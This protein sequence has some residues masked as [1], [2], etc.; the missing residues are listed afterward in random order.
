MVLITAADLRGT[1][2]TESEIQSVLSSPVAEDQVRRLRRSRGRLLE[3]IHSR[4]QALD[5]LD[6]LIYQVRNGEQ[7]HV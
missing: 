1:G 6:Y 4:Q 2:L 3:D 7:A 5:R